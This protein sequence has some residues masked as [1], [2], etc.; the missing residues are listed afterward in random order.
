MPYEPTLEKA[1]VASIRYNLKWYR[2]VHVAVLMCL[3]R[4]VLREP[5]EVTLLAKD[6]PLTWI[7]FL[8]L[9]TALIRY[10]R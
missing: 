2:L 5:L 4:L 10:W 7:V 3:V 6:Y 1:F 9:D 8:I